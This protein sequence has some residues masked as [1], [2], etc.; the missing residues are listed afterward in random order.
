MLKFDSMNPDFNLQAPPLSIINVSKTYA[1][2][3][4]SEYKALRGVS[5]EIKTHGIYGLI[6]PNGAGK[7]TLLRVISN[8]IKP[9]SGEVLIYGAAI[10]RDPL[11]AKYKIGFLSATTGLYSRLSPRETLAYFGRLFD[12]GEEKIEKRIGEL[13]SLFEMDEFIDKKNETLS[14]GQRQRVNIARCLLHEPE[15]F[16]FDEITE[17]LDVMSSTIVIKFIKYLA[18]IKKCVIFSTHDMNLAERLCENII[19]LHRGSIIQSGRINE[20]KYKNGMNGRSLE[21]L[22]MSSIEAKGADSRE[23]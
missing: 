15:I 4:V 1:E 8:V 10:S 17:G 20:L 5:Y 7:T 11:A 6:G 2:G 9:D 22:F 18:E 23:L 19:I 16:V 12:L 3:S 21:D 13:K 14:F